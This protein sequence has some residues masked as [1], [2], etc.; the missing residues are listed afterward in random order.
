MK[1]REQMQIQSWVII[2]PQRQWTKT[3]TTAKQIDSA[4]FV[5]NKSP[6]LNVQNFGSWNWHASNMRSGLRKRETKSRKEVVLRPQA[7]MN[8]TLQLTYCAKLNPWKCPQAN[9]VASSETSPGSVL[10]C[11]LGYI[12]TSRETLAWSATGRKKHNWKQLQTKINMKNGSA[13]CRKV[14]GGNLAH[15]SLETDKECSELGKQ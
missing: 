10:K 14:F 1:I 8:A 12:K 6:K 9:T 4:K 7:N 13:K 2:S 11:T 5:H 15:V 3:K